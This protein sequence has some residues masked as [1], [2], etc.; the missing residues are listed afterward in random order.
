MQSIYLIDIFPDTWLFRNRFSKRHEKQAECCNETKEISIFVSLALPI[1]KPWE[2]FLGTRTLK[3]FVSYTGLWQ[4]AERLDD[5][6][7][8]WANTACD[9]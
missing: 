2:L 4:T 8:Y 3:L 7:K 9:I 5:M 1:R 6:E